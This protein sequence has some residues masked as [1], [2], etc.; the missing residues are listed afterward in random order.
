MW[1]TLISAISDS[2]GEASGHARFAGL[3]KPKALNPRAYLAIELLP[4]SNKRG[5]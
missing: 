2:N 5:A 1:A 3:I 4:S